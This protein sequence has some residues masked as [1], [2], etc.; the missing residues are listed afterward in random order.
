MFCIICFFQTL[1][2]IVAVV[3]LF[4]QSSSTHIIFRVRPYLQFFYKNVYVLTKTGTTWNN[5][6]PSKLLEKIQELSETFQDQTS[7]TTDIT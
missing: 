1:D 4:S 3:T 7:E 2:F 6:I 5:L